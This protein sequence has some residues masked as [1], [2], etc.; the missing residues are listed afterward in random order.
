MNCSMPGLP[1]HLE[2]TQTH[3]HW[4]GDA[5]QSSHPLLSYKNILLKVKIQKSKY[6]TQ[7]IIA[8]Y[9]LETM[10]QVKK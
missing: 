8:V 1:D 9:I 4:V 7:W 3:I 5:I 6:I 2:F 10:T